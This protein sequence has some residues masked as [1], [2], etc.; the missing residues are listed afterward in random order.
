MI[1]L[2]SRNPIGGI[3]KII[4]LAIITLISSEISAQNQDYIIT[5]KGD[6]I[7]GKIER[8]NFTPKADFDNFKAVQ[9]VGY[10]DE[11]RF[12]DD[13]GKETTYA[14]GEI[15]GFY[16]AGRFFE[17]LYVRDLN[18]E[19]RNMVFSQKIVSGTANLYK[20]VQSKLVRAATRETENTIQEYQYLAIAGMP[21]VRMS[22]S[23][24]KLRE[25]LIEYLSND[26]ITLAAINEKGFN[27]SS[28]QGI[29]RDYNLRH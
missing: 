17:S 1:I 8:L 19:G 15:M 2:H 4:T 27:K 23:K 9:R 10:E 11:I 26:E 7:P 14:C 21:T 13:S 28:L 3:L 24:K 20:V 18:K 25:L 6:T 22:K 12:I 16:V 5:Y 29:L